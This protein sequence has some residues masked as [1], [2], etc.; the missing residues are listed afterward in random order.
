MPYYKPFKIE[1]FFSTRR[2]ITD[3]QKSSVVYKFTCDLDGCQ[4]S[5]VGHTRCTLE[6][7]STQHKYNPSNI[8]Q[9]YRDDH[10]QKPPSTISNN[11][12]ILYNYNN[13]IE[14]KIAESLSIREELPSINVK[15][16]ELG[17]FVNIYR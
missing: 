1:S 4:A 15:Y 13:I 7:R 10:S 8:F 6:R 3:F 14:L 17:N 12:K 16:N 11:F 2:K 9:H 5:Y